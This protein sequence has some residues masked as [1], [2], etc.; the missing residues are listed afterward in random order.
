MQISTSAQKQLTTF[1]SP[2]L[3]ISIV[4]EKRLMR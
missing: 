4:M 1:A 3:S 2:H